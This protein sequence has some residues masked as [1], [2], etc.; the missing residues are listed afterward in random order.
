M[1]DVWIP[2]D[3]CLA[4]RVFQLPF[5]QTPDGLFVSFAGEWTLSGH[6]TIQAE[7]CRSG[8]PSKSVF[9]IY[10]TATLELCLIVHWVLGQLSDYSPSACRFSVSVLVFP[11]FLHSWAMEASHWGL[12][13]CRNA[14]V[15]FSQNCASMQSFLEGPETVHWFLWLCLIL[16]NMSFAPVAHFAISSMQ[17]SWD[18]FK[19]ISFSNLS[20]LHACRH[21]ALKSLSERSLRWLIDVCPTTEY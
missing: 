9:S 11:D 19:W 14:S 7:C 13:W 10:R 1:I 15:S 18:A 12:Q 6:V 5:W 20:H 8:Y 2:P 4:F 16:G 21:A 17:F 3:I